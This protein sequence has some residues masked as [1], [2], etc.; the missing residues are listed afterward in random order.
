MLFWSADRLRRLK[1]NFKRLQ[2]AADFVNADLFEWQPDKLF[3]AILLDAPCSSTGTIRRHPDV[4]WTKSSDQV[5]ELAALQKSMIKKSIEFLKPGGTLLFSNCS[6]D[7]AEGENLVAQLLK[8]ETG[9][10]LDPV[11]SDEVFGL[12]ELITGQGTVRTLPFHMQ[13]P[14]TMTNN[15]NLFGLDGFF[16]ARFVKAI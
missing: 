11:T 16:A 5:E 14:A 12:D 7:R 8:E 3:D 2:L 15:P 1:N 9:L 6:I 10:I 13:E 4:Q